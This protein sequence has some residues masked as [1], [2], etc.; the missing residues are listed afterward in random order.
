VKGLSGDASHDRAA[1]EVGIFLLDD[2]PVF[3]RTG[4]QSDTR[5]RVS[6]FTD[7]V[8][9][10][11]HSTGCTI[12]RTSHQRRGTR[13]TKTANGSKRSR[14]A[15]KTSLQVTWNCRR[16][17]E[18]LGRMGM[19]VALRLSV[20]RRSVVRES[21]RVCEVTCVISDLFE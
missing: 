16:E 2:C 4:Q 6:G 7:A 18:T 10:S 12:H 20:H 13:E 3:G 17:D 5:R 8:A 19:A 1:I 9:T 11:S 14:R 21:T 15:T